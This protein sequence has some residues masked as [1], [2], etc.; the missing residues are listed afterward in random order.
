MHSSSATYNVQP[1]IDDMGGS[2]VS[3]KP[4]SRQS[5]SWVLRT[6]GSIAEFG[7]ETDTA[8]S[9][10]NPE[11]RHAGNYFLEL[12]SFQRDRGPLDVILAPYR[13]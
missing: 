4:S 8:F 5:L 2:N 9:T 6:Y 11:T 7:F 10:K 12:S 13:R 1:S 3:R